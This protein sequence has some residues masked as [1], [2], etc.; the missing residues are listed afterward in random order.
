MTQGNAAE[1][2]AAATQPT[3]ALSA[4]LD[5]VILGNPV[6]AWLFAAAAALVAFA[7]VLLA[8]RILLARA[9]ALAERRK[10][11]IFGLVPRVVLATSSIVAVAAAV[12]AA[13]MWLVLSD[14][15]SRVIDG[16]LVALLAVQV[17]LWGRL[18]V[19]YLIDEFLRRRALASGQDAPDGA[20]LASAG[21]MRFLALTVLYAA[22]V[23]LA[24]ENMNVDVTALIAGLGIGGIAVALAAQNILGDL[25]GSLS[26]VL[27]KPFVVGDFIIVGEQLGTVERIGI[28]TTRVRSLS[29]EQLVFANSDLLSSRIRNYKRMAERRV[30][31]QLRVTLQTPPEKL[32]LAQKILK[33][34][35]LAQELVRFDRAHFFAFGESSFVFEV[36][37]Y[38]L[39][40]DY[41]VYMD[42]QQAINLHIVRR[43]AQEGISLAYPAQ[44][45]FIAEGQVQAPVPP[46]PR[47]ASA[48]LGN[49][50][51]NA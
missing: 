30:V 10:E 3:P 38:V 1:P 39:S 43:F 7:A 47:P 27:D 36:V 45:L 42:R 4:V 51:K 41:N 20:V 44:T 18:V 22:V 31:F 46:Q 32:E 11:G 26:I 21:V 25:F 17:M 49:G 9:R 19:E 2:V 29:G 13:S 33:E 5:T 37:Y 16:L 12:F 24:L 48:E 50:S 6:S 40:S 8:R 35:V 23:L 15:A 28:K 34:A 14:R